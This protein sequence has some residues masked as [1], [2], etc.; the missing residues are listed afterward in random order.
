[1]LGSIKDDDLMLGPT[2]EDLG[3][4]K[5]NVSVETDNE[6]FKKRLAYKTHGSM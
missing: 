2:E 5:G 1:M 6:K 4:S 3:L